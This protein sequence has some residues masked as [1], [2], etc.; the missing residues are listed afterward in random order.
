MAIFKLKRRKTIFHPTLF[1]LIPWVLT[2][3]A[4]TAPP[5][6]PNPNNPSSNVSQP[7]SKPT[8]D[9]SINPEQFPF[10]AGVNPLTGKPIKDPA[11]L[12][13]S[14]VLV[15][16]SNFPGATRPQMGLSFAT[17]IYEFWIGVGMT[18]FLSIYYGDFPHYQ[19]SMIGDCAVRWEVFQVP[20]PWI[21][22][23]VWFDENSNG[24]QDLGE[25]GV[26]GICLHL[27][28]AESHTL[29]AG[30]TTDSNGYYGFH[31]SPTQRVILKV[32]LPLGTAFSP[33]H[34]GD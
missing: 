11:L 15:S 16:V 12:D 6:P 19:P 2:S 17:Q 24:I 5:Q 27:I 31:V 18:R 26:P 33:L 23:I 34:Q 14:P 3:A 20:E 32:I 13:L 30:T 28:D 7:T 29:L 1:L 21:G 8:A 25:R 9:S 4:G 10:S 22:N